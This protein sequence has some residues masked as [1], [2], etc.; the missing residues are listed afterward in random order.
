[1]KRDRLN[2]KLFNTI[3]GTF[4]ISY[5]LFLL[6][7]LPLYFIYYTPSFSLIAISTVLYFLTG[8]SITA[9][10]H[11]LYSHKAYK[12]HPIAE[13]FLLFFG[14]MSAQGSALRWCYDHRLHHAHVDTDRDPYSIK[15]GFWYAHML[16]IFTKPS[17]IDPKVVP[18]LMRNRYLV[19][20]DT[21]YPY[22]IAFTNILAF[23]LVGWCLND[24]M[25]AFMIAVWVR[26]FALHHSTWFINSLAHTLGEKPFSQEVSA[27]DNYILSILT[28]GE[29]YHNYHH[30]FANDYRNGIKWYHYDPTKWL[31]WTFK[32]LRLAYQLKEMDPETIAKRMVIEK[33]DLMLDRLKELW[34]VKRDEVEK[35]IH[36]FSENLL[37]KMARFNELKLE[38]RR[39]K[40]EFCERDHLAKLQEELK[41]LKKSLKRDLRNW[42]SLSSM[43]LN[44]K[45]LKS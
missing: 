27:V 21:Y 5:H 37:K 32:R 36:E 10:Y 6:F 12:A 20:Q 4:I 39:L 29:G 38:Y 45:T 30:T 43:I 8:M 35:K 26:L 28:F 24:Y 2:L 41:E 44:L 31:I 40:K 33:K 11:R 25:G 13:L 42:K 3:P 18:D 9:G 1:M 22:L 17:P 14:T 15:K 19:F 7:A 16:W 34:Y 23:L